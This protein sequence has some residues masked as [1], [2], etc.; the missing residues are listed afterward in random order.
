MLVAG[1]AAGGVAEGVGCTGAGAGL[2]GLADA[3]A[4]AVAGGVEAAGVAGADAGVGF[5][6]VV[7]GFVVLCVFVPLA[8]CFFTL[9]F[10]GMP[11]T[12]FTPPTTPPV[13]PP[14]APPTAAPTG[15]AALLPTAAPS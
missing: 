14:T 8:V 5:V 15:P 3:G 4:G 13:T 6:A 1:A 7:F 2:E 12:P 11:S 9:V 10:W